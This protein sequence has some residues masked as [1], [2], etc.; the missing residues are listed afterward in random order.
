MRNPEATLNLFHQSGVGQFW[1]PM[2]GQFSMPTDTQKP[3]P[4][5]LGRFSSRLTRCYP[6]LMS[7]VSSF[8]FTA[9]YVLG[10]IS[11]MR[12]GRR[13]QSM[14]HGPSN[15]RCSRPLSLGGMEYNG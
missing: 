15:C 14:W 10:A 6:C 8:L 11:P 3:Y 5:T 12:A 4:G 2:V 1:T 13:W 7:T 9:G